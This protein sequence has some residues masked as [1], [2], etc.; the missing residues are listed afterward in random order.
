MV[1][2]TGCQA[3]VSHFGV[4]IVSDVLKPGCRVSGEV[5]A[6]TKT[7]EPGGGR[8]RKTA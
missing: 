3:A 8:S 5:R 1:L 4:T 7:Q 6:G 2:P